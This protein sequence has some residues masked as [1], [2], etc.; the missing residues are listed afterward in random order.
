MSSNLR[1]PPRNPTYNL[2][3]DERSGAEPVDAGVIGFRMLRLWPHRSASV[4]IQWLKPAGTTN[5]HSGELH[6]E[7]STISVVALICATGS[8]C[9]LYSPGADVKALL[10]SAPP[11]SDYPNAGY[12]NLIDEAWYT[13]RADGSWI[14]RTRT[15]QKICNERGRS[16]RGERADCVQ[17]RVRE[18]QD[19]PR[20][21]DSK[22]DGTVI[23]VKP[24]E[25]QEVTPYSGYA[26]YSSVKAKVLIMPAVED[27]CII[28]YEWE[29]SGRQTI[30]PP[31]FWN[32]WYFQSS[33]PTVLSRFTLQTPANAAS[34][35]R[36][37]TPRSSRW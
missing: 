12:I 22:K 1:H 20:A 28:D 31:H 27:D 19:P 30:M 2:V 18:D 15:T 25:I 13:I 21:D 9:R 23:E 34:A 10:E 33:E 5:P 37:T 16:R 17:L 3:G 24:S 26:M 36:T 29:I 8:G 4:I 11:S 7:P 35:V 32:G 6:E 14:S